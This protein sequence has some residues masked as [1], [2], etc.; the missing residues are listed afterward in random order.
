MMVLIVMRGLFLAIDLLKDRFFGCVDY[1]WGE[2]RVSI[3]CESYSRPLCVRLGKE[4]HNRNKVGASAQ[5][6][7]TG[8]DLWRPEMSETANS[9]ILAL[10]VFRQVA[11]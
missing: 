4:V 3:F 2:C 11:I 8:E 6:L 9:K 1:E 10:L 7:L 5:L